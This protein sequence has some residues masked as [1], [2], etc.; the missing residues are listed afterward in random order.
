MV[1]LGFWVFSTFFRSSLAS[2]TCVLL[3]VSLYSGLLK[4]VKVSYTLSNLVVSSCFRL[5]W[6]F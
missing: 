3:V 2:S 6:S 1:A 5:F 4:I